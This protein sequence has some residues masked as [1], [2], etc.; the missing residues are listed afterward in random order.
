MSQL[1]L[2]TTDPAVSEVVS[3]WQAGGTYRIELI[4]TQ[5]E[6]KG[7]LVPFTVDEITDY[8]DPE[9]D[10]EESP[11]PEEEGGPVG[12]RAQISKVPIPSPD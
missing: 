4:I 2:D 9:S 6:S 12:N 5:G 7:A 8:G 11:M 3:Q 10:E 1:I